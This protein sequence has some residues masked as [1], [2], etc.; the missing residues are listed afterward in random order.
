MMSASQIK[1]KHNKTSCKNRHKKK[2]GQVG[3]KKKLHK[4]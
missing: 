3:V 2:S 1:G 4:L